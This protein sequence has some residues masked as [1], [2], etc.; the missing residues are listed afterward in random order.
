MII[1]LLRVRMGS[2]ILFILICILCMR[3][4]VCRFLMVF[5]VRGVCFVGLI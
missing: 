1:L 3:L 5:V 2:L 4:L